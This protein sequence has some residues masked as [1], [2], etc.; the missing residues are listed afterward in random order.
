MAKRNDVRREVA[1]RARR[2]SQRPVGALG[3]G[4]DAAAPG[5]LAGHADVVRLLL[6]AGADPTIRDSKHDSD[7]IGWATFFRRTDVIEMLKLK[8]PSR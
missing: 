7:A 5:G 2:R 1:A 4:R 3:R 8:P 6:D